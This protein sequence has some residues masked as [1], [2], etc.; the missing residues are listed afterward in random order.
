MKSKRL[1]LKSLVDAQTIPAIEHSCAQ[2][3]AVTIMVHG[4]TTDKD[5]YL[6]FYRNIAERLNEQEVASL[7]FDSRAH[8]E[9]KR[10]S[11][12]FTIVNN[13]LD[14]LSVVMEAQ[15]K[16]PGIPLKLFGTSFG[17]ISAAIAARLLS[18]SL[19]RLILLAPAL[20][21]SALYIDPVSERE[22]YASFIHQAV[23]LGEQLRVSDRISFTAANAVE[24]ASIDMRSV[25]ADVA[26]RLTVIHG[27][28]DT[29]IPFRLTEEVTKSN[30]IARFIPVEGMDHGFMDIEDPNG[31]SSRSRENFELILSELVG[32]R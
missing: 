1:R 21:L 25:I 18:V 4:L 11:S 31:T 13:T 16:Y 17:S 23:H 29:I 19:D 32:D 14:V 8:G 3:T 22:K 30:P 9:S 2:P 28:S 24:F 15:R 26:S 20:N 6:G 7:R 27:L 10:P 12:E 5:E